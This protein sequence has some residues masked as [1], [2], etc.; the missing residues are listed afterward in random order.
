M[1]AVIVYFWHWR[2][3]RNL[4]AVPRLFPFRSNNFNR[5]VGVAKSRAEAFSLALAV[6]LTPPVAIPALSQMCR[7]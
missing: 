5:H 2:R 6:V 1:F 7:C 3:S 4:P